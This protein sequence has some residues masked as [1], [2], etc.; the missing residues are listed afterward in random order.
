M[1]PVRIN[2][3]LDNCISLRRLSLHQEELGEAVV[4]IYDPIRGNMLTTRSIIHGMGFRKIEGITSFEVLTRRLKTNDA[5]ILFIEASE[6]T[7]IVIELLQ[8]IRMGATKCNPFLPIIVTLWVGSSDTITGLLNSGCDDVLLRPFSVSKTQERV[9][10]I[11]YNRKKFV[12]TSDYVGP[13]RGKPKEGQVTVDAFE[14]PN[15]L[16]D[17]I[18]G[19]AS[20]PIKQNNDIDEAKKRV[21]KERLAK[22]ARR[23]AIAAEVT[24]Q[25]QAKPSTNSGFVTDLLETTYELVRTAKRMNNDDIHDMAIVLEN[26]ASKTASGTNTVENA[27]LTRQLAYGIYAAYA[28][29]N[30]E[31]FRKDLELTLSSVRSRLDKAKDRETKLK[32]LNEQVEGTNHEDIVKTI[33]ESTNIEDVGVLTSRAA[34]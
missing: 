33:S 17:I 20:N 7:D 19:D 32:H 9:K 22:L 15:P 8:A 25:A 1:L 3:N 12:V 14:V 10:S 2:S 27:K 26:I 30:D 24:L 34:S 16:R 29:G 11:I 4:L 6:N 18:T 31:A 5:S 28:S 23:I 13:D 21:N